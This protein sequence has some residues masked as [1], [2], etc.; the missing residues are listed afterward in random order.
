M[1]FWVGIAGV[2]WQDVAVDPA[3]LKK[4]LLDTKDFDANGRW[5]MI[6]GDSAASPPVRD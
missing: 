4:G 1:V 5:A 2:P 3:D 6:V